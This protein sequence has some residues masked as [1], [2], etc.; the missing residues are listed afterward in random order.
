[1]LDT[2]HAI[3]ELLARNANTKHAGS[4]TDHT[5]DRQHGL[6][7]GAGLVFDLTA[8]CG[9]HEPLEHGAGASVEVARGDRAA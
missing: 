4:G 2:L 9:L 8:H 1:M 6:Q 5:V 3:N 7:I